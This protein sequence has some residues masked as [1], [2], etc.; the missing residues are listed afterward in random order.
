[1][2]PDTPDYATVIHW[3]E[4]CA[5]LASSRGPKDSA[6]LWQDGLEHL[7]RLTAE[8]EALRADAERYRWLRH[9]DNDD[10]IIICL[11]GTSA[12]LPRNSALNSAIDKA[13]AK[14][15]P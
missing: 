9:G 8:N 1:V 6:L 10:E 12:Y 3:F 14:E 7:K 13:M 4:R 15:Q 2:K 5:S 11:G